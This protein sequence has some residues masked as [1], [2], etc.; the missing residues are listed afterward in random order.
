MTAEESRKLRK[1]EKENAELKARLEQ[2]DEAMRRTLASY[3]SDE[4]LEEVLEKDRSV[5]IGG[6]RRVVTMMFT[7]IRRSTQL[8]EHMNATDFIEMLNHYLEEMIEIVNAWQGNILSFVGDAIVAVFGAP[9]PN[10]D[11][12]RDAVACAVAMQRRMPMVN[13]WNAE[14]GFP[15][16]SMGIGIHTGEAILGNIGSQTRAKYDMIGRN[17]NL[18]SRI[19]GF[20]GD[21]EILIST[22]TLEAAGDQV[23]LNPEGERRVRPKG[24]Q[25]DI[26]VHQVIGYGSR[27]IKTEMPEP[28]DAAPCDEGPG[29]APATAGSPELFEWR[30]L[31]EGQFGRKAE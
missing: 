21:N 8:S 30:D 28:K 13:F 6:E 18:A 19:E 25:T 26:L 2:R 5:R 14:H 3:L 1:L 9:R 23:I 7:D 27:M 29:S 10:E 24:I 11:A 31:D 15:D 4:V 16:L 12:A 22:E 17:V 20:T